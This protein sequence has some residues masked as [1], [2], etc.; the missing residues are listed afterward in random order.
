VVPKLLFKIDADRA[1][2]REP[3][4]RDAAFDSAAPIRGEETLVNSTQARATVKIAVERAWTEVL[5]PESCAA[6]LSLSDAGGDSLDALRMWVLI[7]ETLDAK[8][9]MDAL[10]SDTTPSLLTAAIEQQLRAVF[11]RP[12]ALASTLAAP[13]VFLTPPAD[14]DSPKLA[15]FRAVFKDRIRFVLIEYPRWREMIDGGAGFDLLVDA[16]VAQIRAQIRQNDPC[17]LTGY[18]FGGLVALETARRLAQLGCRVGH[19]GLVDTRTASPSTTPPRRWRIVIAR[20]ISMSA[21]RSLKA[22]G[23]L[24]A[25]FPA[26]R[27]FKIE[28]EL[29]MQLRRSTLRR[30]RMAPLEIP[31]TIYKSDDIQSPLPSDG[32]SAQCSRLEV[33]YIGGTHDTILE[34]PLLDT[35]SARFLEGVSPH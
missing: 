16:A 5:G 27:A 10:T 6:D 34:P 13:V 20:L 21:F 26:N 7:E 32:W 29:N 4:T 11:S 9:C 30:F 18:S 28:F 24:A 31:I 33:V 25:L 35:L 19:V 22:V 2:I 1:L 15:R 17:H 23:Q 3:S 12:V 8:L 14:G